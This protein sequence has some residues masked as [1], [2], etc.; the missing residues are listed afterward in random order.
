MY[1]NQYLIENSY[2]GKYGNTIP[3]NRYYKT[4]S[5]NGK[6]EN[7]ASSVKNFLVSESI[8]FILQKTLL[9][10][11]STDR[12]LG[13]VLCENFVKEIGA[14]TLIRRFERES[15]TLAEMALLI[16]ESYDNIMC[17]VDKQDNLTF[18]IKPSDKKSF[19]DGLECLDVDKIVEKINTRSCDAAAEFI[20]NN[21][22][23]KLDMEEIANKAKEKIDK[24][25]AKSQEQRDKFVKEHTMYARQQADN[26]RSRRR[27]NIYEEMVLKMSS[28]IMKNKDISTKFVSESGKLDVDMIIEKVDVMYRFLETVNTARIYGINESYLR[29]VIDSIK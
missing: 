10:K 1:T 4:A 12:E 6:F 5:I 13:K 28:Q 20:Q 18:C 16:N 19:Y 29:S 23:D 27:K 2:S 26:V 17:K 14:N 8:N 7:F 15:C 3:E 25:K 21:I 22:N 9:E 11:S 24:I